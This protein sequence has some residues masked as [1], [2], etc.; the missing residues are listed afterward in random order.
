MLILGKFAFGGR[1]KKYLLTIIFILV[2]FAVPLFSQAADTTAPATSANNAFNYTPMEKIPGFETETVGNF[3]TYIQAVYKFGIWAVGISAL[4]MI[5]IGGF[6]Y[7]T[8]AGNNTAMEKAKGV[9]TDAVIGLVLALTAYLLLYIINPDL[10]KIKPL[11]IIPAKA[12]T[13]QPPVGGPPLAPTPT[14]SLAVGCDNY[15]DVFDYSSEG[16]KNL[17]CLLI[18][19]A[20]QES[21]CN[22]NAVSSH[23]ACGLMQML[24]ATAGISCDELKNDP[25]KSIQLAAGFLKSN[26]NTIPSSSGFDIGKS[27]SLSGNYVSYGNFKYDTGNDDLIASYNAGSGKLATTPGMKGPFEISTDCPSPIT[28]AW[29]CHIN[30]SGFSQTQ[31]Y[32]VRVQSF[33]TQCLAK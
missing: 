8:S 3:Y 24:P 33:Q 14:G 4:L 18:G 17:K 1:N 15:L 12:P 16:D 2:F 5:S 25:N 32:V 6:M 27:F 26:Q 22:P 20:N 23:G 29:Q 19:I 13:A 11:P 31:N 28:P 10:V 30:P 9:I 21:G 7:I